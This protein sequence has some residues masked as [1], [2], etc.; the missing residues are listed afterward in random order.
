[1]IETEEQQ[2]R[3]EACTCVNHPDVMIREESVSL[4]YF[5]FRHVA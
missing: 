3:R 5:I 1:M 4:W 2:L